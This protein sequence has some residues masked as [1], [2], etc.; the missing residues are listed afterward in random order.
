MKIAVHLKAE[1]FDWS[2]SPLSMNKQFLDKAK[3]LMKAKILKQTG[4]KW[5]C[6]DKT[7]KGGTTSDGNCARNILQHNRE[8]VVSEVPERLQDVLRHYG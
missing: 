3:S 4:R 7:G 5:D 1:V 8:I 6:P 2:E